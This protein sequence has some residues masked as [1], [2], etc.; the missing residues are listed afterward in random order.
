MS[1]LAREGVSHVAYEASSHGL[2]QFRNEGLKVKAGAFTN[3]SRDHLDY[4]AGMEDYF[5]AKMRL[6]DTLLPTGAPAVIRGEPFWTDCALYADAGIPVVLFGAAGTG[7]H[8]AT[9]WVSLD[10]VEIVTRVLTDLI[11]DVCA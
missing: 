5:A 6:F 2:S 3:L 1:G 8:A 7:A 10:S 4:H 11:L 9:E